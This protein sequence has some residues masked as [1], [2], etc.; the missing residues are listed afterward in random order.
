GTAPGTDS[1]ISE[2]K[3]RGY[4]HFANKIWNISRFVMEHS[5]GAETGAP[6]TMLV[7]DF[8]KIVAEITADIEGYRLHLASEKLYAYVWHEFADKIIEESKPALSGADEA[9]KKTRAAE[10]AFIWTQCVKLLHPF[11]PFIT[12]EIWGMLPESHKT[13]QMLMVEKWPLQKS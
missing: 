4:K 8:R 7:Q 5:A 1:T 2:A 9:A 13:Q 3:I 12:E 10:L 11:M 6:D